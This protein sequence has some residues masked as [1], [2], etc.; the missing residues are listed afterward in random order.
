MTK[1]V[2]LSGKSGKDSV[3]MEPSLLI[4]AFKLFDVQNKDV[5]DPLLVP[6]PL[7]P[8]EYV[9]RY[10]IISF[11]TSGPHYCHSFFTALGLP[12][13]TLGINPDT[14]TEHKRR[15]L[16]LDSLEVFPFPTESV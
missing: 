2:A 3:E 4:D 8:H 13:P 12:V 11:L 15:A 6:R 1:N 7:N 5:I 10:D 14:G 9:T 16:R